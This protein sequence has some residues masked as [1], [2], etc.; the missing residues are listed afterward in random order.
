MGGLG[1]GRRLGRVGRL[2]DGG[3]VKGEV[4]W[5]SWMEGGF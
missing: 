2:E 1:R 3:F 4:G 5:A